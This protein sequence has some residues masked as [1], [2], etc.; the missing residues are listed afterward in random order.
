[1]ANSKIVNIK[2][3][4]SSKR[5]RG[6][7]HRKSRRKRPVASLRDGLKRVNTAQRLV[8]IVLIGVFVIAGGYS[9]YKI[10]YL[11]MEKHRLNEE[12]I[13]LQREREQLKEQLKNV[14]DLE[15]IEEE[16]REK[17]NLILPGE[18]IYKFSDDEGK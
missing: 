14:Q 2:S 6:G 4:E 7:A 11:S 3:A 12:K 8:I 1:M 18:V 5:T 16:A 17:L 15:Y 9:V 10:G 13:T